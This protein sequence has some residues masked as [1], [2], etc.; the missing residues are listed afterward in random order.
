MTF[1]YVTSLVAQHEGGD[2]RPY[3]QAWKLSSALM[4]WPG[5][6]AEMMSSEENKHA[7]FALYRRY[8]ESQGA[9]IPLKIPEGY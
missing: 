7:V 6:F 3:F 4:G 2:S 8:F 9:A 5:D 1:G